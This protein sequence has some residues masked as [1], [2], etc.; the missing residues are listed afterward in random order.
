MVSSGVPVQKECVSEFISMKLKKK[1]IRFIIYGMGD[2]L[3]EIKIL[4]IGESNLTYNDLVSKLPA[5]HCRFAVINFDFE[6][7][8]GPREKCLFVSW[9][10]TKSKLKEKMVYTSS[11]SEFKKQ[12]DGCSIELNADCIAEVAYEEALARCVKYVQ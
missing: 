12:L 1:D 3:D 9:A 7:E 6:I 8:D 2:K 5:D 4:E 11:K 10:P